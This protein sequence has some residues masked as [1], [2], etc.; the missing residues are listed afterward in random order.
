VGL[1]LLF[2]WAQLRRGYEARIASIRVNHAP[3]KDKVLI[4]GTLVGL[5]SFLPYYPYFQAFLA[6]ASANYTWLLSFV[7][8]QFYDVEP[9][10]HRSLLFLSY[11]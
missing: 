7:I 1:V 3:R 4:S 11:S 6:V 8:R 10:T 5:C 9:F 2:P